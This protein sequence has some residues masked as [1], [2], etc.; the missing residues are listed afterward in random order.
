MIRGVIH[1]NH[2]LVKIGV[3]SQFGILEI[4]ALVDTGFTSE[5]KV[6]YTI[7]LEL[8]LQSTH[9][10]RMELADE[11]EVYWKASLASVALEGIKQTVN[12]L[13][14]DGEMS[15]IGVG[16]LRKFGYNLRL[17]LKYDMLMLEKY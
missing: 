5:L 4:I 10:E 16:L 11:K 15:I 2:P 17:D 7:A 8:N 3:E 9:T 14:S 12:V 6:S 1:N 13:I